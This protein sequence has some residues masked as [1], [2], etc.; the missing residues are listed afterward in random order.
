[1]SKALL[2]AIA[3]LL[4]LFAAAV[5]GVR[6]ATVAS[7]PSPDAADR[8]AASLV[9]PAGARTAVFA[10]GCFWGTEEAF[11]AE[12]GVLETQVGY[13]GGTAAHPTYHSIHSAAGG[14]YAESVLV[15]YDPARTTYEQLLRV[16]FD[17]HDPTAPRRREPGDR[18]SPYRSFVAVNTAA[19]RTQAER[20]IAEFAR[21]KS[22]A[23][24]VR[25]AVV[26]RMPF[27]PAEEHHQHYYAK[28][29]ESG[30]IVGC[31]L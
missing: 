7:L 1:M 12:P 14:G 4:A 15:V 19:E 11:R 31:R 8:I 2:V 6:R 21:A 24:P 27:H 13:A 25:T 23:Y 10:A 9:V 20:M 22:F 16:F 17:H 5:T 29:A 30:K 28:N 18:V 26:P 3:C